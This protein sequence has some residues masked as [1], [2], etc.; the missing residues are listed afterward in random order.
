MM[1]GSANGEC[2]AAAGVPQQSN[3][4]GDVLAGDNITTI[5]QKVFFGTV[6]E[7]PQGASCKVFQTQPVWH[8][9]YVLPMLPVDPMAAGNI[10]SPSHRWIVFRTKKINAADF[11]PFG[12][13]TGPQWASK[14]AKLVAQNP[15]MTTDGSGLGRGVQDF[16][17]QLFDCYVQGCHHFWFE[18]MEWT[19]LADSSVYPAGLVDPP[20]FV[21]YIRFFPNGADIATPSTTPDYNVVDRIYAHGQP[22]PSREMGLFNPG[23]NHWAIVNSY[24]Q[25]N[26][27]VQG[28]FPIVNPTMNGPVITIPK[29][30]YQNNAFDNTPI[31]MTGNATATF[32]APGSYAGV[33]YAWID[34]DGLTIDYQTGAGVTLACA[35]CIAMSEGNPARNSVPSTSLFFFN[36]HFSNGSA[37]LDY[38]APWTGSPTVLASSRPMGIYH[39][40]GNFAYVDNNYISAIGQTVYNDTDGPRQDGTWTHNYFYFPRS[41]MQNSGQWD[42]YGYTF[43]NVLETKQALRWRLEGNIFDGSAAHQNPGTAVFIVGAYAAPFSNG[44]Q[45]ISIRN[46]IFKHLSSGF[47]CAGGGAQAPPDSPTAAR[48]EVFN[49]LFLDLNRDLY[50]NGGGGLFSGP[51]SS[52]PGCEDMNIHRNTV[53][54]TL[55]S[56]PALFLMGAA[57]NGSSVMGEG[58]NFTDNEMHLSLNAL[59]ALAVICGQDVPSH[60]AYPASLCA[61]GSTGTTYKQ[62]LDSSYM[63]AGSTITGSWNLT[64]NVIIG[65]LTTRGLAAWTDIDQPTL[66]GIAANFPAGNIFPTGPT[67]SA[68]RAAVNWN[69]VTYRIVPSVW[70]PG[71]IG[72]DVDSITSATGTVTNI[73]VS[74][75]PSATTAVFTY[76]APDSRACSVDVISSNASATRTADSGG[77]TSRLVSVSGLLPNSKYQYRV[78]CYF[79]QAAQYEFLPGQITTAAFTTSR[80]LP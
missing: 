69:P 56:G 76:T 35:G 40:P 36:G 2:V 41:K 78:M 57:S 74:V 13:R 65:G 53:D 10:D 5:L 37:V 70:N 46:N 19:H 67:M 43:R 1:V 27:W 17:G 77:A 7:F 54:L 48:I 21:N 8:T 79:D 75:S 45:D 58:L 32:Q 4:N 9:G 22:W 71:N 59:D 51:F 23:G 18:N 16:N 39:Y 11:P 62:M 33:F 3:W 42:G 60:P 26:M 49:N 12:V 31:G 72:A 64:N 50:N 38:S 80:Q 14:L 44:T 15:G 25:A 24:A 30:V 6:I 68:R 66:S 34:R 55:G 73:A 20:A 28:V 63:H 61:G 47:Q 52:Y 29:S